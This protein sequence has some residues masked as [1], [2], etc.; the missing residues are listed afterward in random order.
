MAMSIV[1]WMEATGLAIKEQSKTDSRAK[2]LKPTELGRL[3]HKYD[4]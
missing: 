3:V 2:I 1:Y 4:P